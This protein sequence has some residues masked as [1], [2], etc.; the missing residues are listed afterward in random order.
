MN[1]KLFINFFTFT[2][3]TKDFFT[4]KYV[5]PNATFLKSDCTQSVTN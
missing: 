5:I 4:I 3:L 1:F 2:I